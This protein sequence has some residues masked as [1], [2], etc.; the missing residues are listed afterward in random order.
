MLH[1][2]KA[3]P[4][5]PDNRAGALYA[6]GAIALALAMR[7]A[8][9]GCPH[10]Q[11]LGESVVTNPTWGSVVNLTVIRRKGGDQFTTTDNPGRHRAVTAFNGETP[12]RYRL[13]VETGYQ[14][15]TL[16]QMEIAGVG[17]T[18]YARLTG[19]LK[20]GTITDR[21]GDIAAA[22][23]EP[24]PGASGRYRWWINLNLPAG[25]GSYN[26]SILSY[27]NRP[28]FDGTHAACRVIFDKPSLALTSG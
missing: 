12:G 5:M 20:A 26:F 25:K 28:E 10:P 6:S 7:W 24:V 22:G 13:S 17:G 1:W 3:G 9:P 15:A 11:G 8:T 27:D 2:R 4:I 16:F 21:K 23:V 14:T 19:D 18:P